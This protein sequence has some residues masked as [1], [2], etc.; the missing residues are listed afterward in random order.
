MKKNRPVK[1]ASRQRAI[2]RDYLDA[3]T[4]Y[5]WSQ[6][7]DPALWAEQSLHWEDRIG[8]PLDQW[9]IDALRST[10][11]SLWNCTRQAGKSTVAAAKGL[12][13]ATFIPDS[14]VLLVSPS[15]RQSSELFRKVQDHYEVQENRLPLVEDNKL[16]CEF[17]NGSRIVSLPGEEKTIRGFSKP[18]LIIEDEASRVSDELF[19]AVTPMLAVSSRGQII[20]MST[21]FGKRGH[22]FD[23]WT[24]G[25]ETWS[26]TEI[27][28]WEIPRITPE[29][30]EKE[31]LR[32]GD[33]W[34]AQEYCCEFVQ[35]VD[36]VFSYDLIMDALTD[37]IPPLYLGGNPA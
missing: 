16:S 10:N 14:L 5:H 8:G 1:R 11:D 29:F 34:I 2:R 17:T 4:Y 20:L 25:G 35:T 37:D 22:F 19:A 28:W 13:V 9:Q 3:F 32:L 26:R 27:P 18:R 23:M 30:I 36:Q 6:S 24:N 12:H 7:K 21:P 31:R 15:Q 33:W